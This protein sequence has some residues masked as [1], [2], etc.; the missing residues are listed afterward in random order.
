V[1]RES[2]QT[3]VDG[4]TEATIQAYADANNLSRGDAIRMMVH[5]GLAHRDDDGLID[6]S[7]RDRDRQVL[8]QRQ[9]DIANRQHQ[10]I[11]FQRIAVFGGIGWAVVTLATGA[12]GPVWAALGMLAIVLMATSTY[13]WEYFPSFD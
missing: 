6:A 4:E 2:I 9:L 5:T 3:R 13:I 12:T 11:R 10:I 1:S 7:E 8:E